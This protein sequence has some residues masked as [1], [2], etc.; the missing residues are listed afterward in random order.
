L[1]LSA[2]TFSQ[3]WGFSS[4][5]ELSAGSGSAL[6]CLVRTGRQV[7]SEIQQAL[8]QHRMG[9]LKTG[10]TVELSGYTVRF[11]DGP[12]LYILYKDIFIRRIYHPSASRPDPFIL[13][14]GS[15]IGMSILYFKHIYPAARIIG[16]EPDPE[17]MPYL[18]E[19]IA[20]NNLENVH[21]VQ[22][23]LSRDATKKIL[24]SDGKC[25]SGLAAPT[26]FDN[27]AEWRKY[28]VSSVRLRDYLAEPVDFLKMNIEGAE[29]EVLADSEDRLRQISEMIIEYHHLPG[30]PRSLH[31]ILQILHRQ[32]FE[33]LINDFDSQTN[34][35]VQPP[36][37][38][39]PE[40]R[41][42]LLIYA[43]R[44]DP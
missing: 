44:L 30:L 38:L 27:P 2:S 23:V 17:V 18:E 10:S 29:L 13:D 28:E 32:R 25:G 20:R 19:N 1:R 31:D 4:L 7:R 37:R 22:A 43:K 34:G 26:Q 6:R 12:N 36:F 8:L 41:Y 40:S 39:T 24:Y 21:C 11:N 5:G 33:Y 3:R 15:N 42:F 35:G 14:C 9:A 16:F